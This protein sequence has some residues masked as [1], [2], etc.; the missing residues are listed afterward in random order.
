[1]VKTAKV[2]AIRKFSSVTFSPRVDPKCLQEFANIR[3][4]FH[5]SHC[6]DD[7]GA[8]SD[9]ALTQRQ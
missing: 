3:N 9:G 1:M 6:C 2:A 4:E 5:N 8:T 7:A